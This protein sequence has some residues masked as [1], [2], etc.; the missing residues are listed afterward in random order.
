ML[1]PQELPDVIED[2]SVVVSDASISRDLWLQTQAWIGSG[3]ETKNSSTTRC[4][5][6]CSI[7]VHWTRSACHIKLY[8]RSCY[9][10]LAS[11]SGIKLRREDNV[12]YGSEIDTSARGS[13]TRIEVGYRGGGALLLLLWQLN[14]IA[15]AASDASAAAAA[16]STSPGSECCPC[17]CFDLMDNE[18]YI[19]I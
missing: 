13:Q 17:Y 19:Y 4:R 9:N 6:N 7:S 5:D 11:C 16:V 3:K 18:Y 1:D 2:K 10:K 14:A 12:S 15:T 8:L